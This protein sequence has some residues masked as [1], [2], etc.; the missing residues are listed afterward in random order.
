MSMDYQ[1]L[2]NVFFGF[3]AGVFGWFAK[4]VWQDIK[5]VTKALAE[6]RVEIAI[7]Y[8]PRNDFKEFSAE[9]REMFNKV[10]DKLDN[11]ADK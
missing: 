7:N 9:I 3:T 2:F 1:T 10:M 4:Q 8:V 5:D 11:K 6:L